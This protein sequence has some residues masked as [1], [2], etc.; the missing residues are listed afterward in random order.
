MGAQRTFSKSVDINALPERVWKIMSDVERWSEWTASVISIRRLDSGPLKIGS[1][2]LIRQPKLPPAMWKVVELE[3]QSFTWISW[4]PGVRV[5][6]KHGVQASGQGTH[7]TLWLRY[8]GLLG[9]LLSWLTL[10]VNERYLNME[11][12]GLKRRSEETNR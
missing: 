10:G 11:A 4:A 6:A 8:E 2:A 5:V 3:A 7:A 12:Q 1:R 9:G